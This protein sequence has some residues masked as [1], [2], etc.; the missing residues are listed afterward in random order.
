MLMNREGAKDTKRGRE[1]VERVNIS[2][3]SVFLRVLRAFAVQ[4]PER[5]C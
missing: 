2:L 4:S 5:S 3:S 1:E